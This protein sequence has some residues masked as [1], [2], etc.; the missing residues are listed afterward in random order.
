MTAWPLRGAFRNAGEI[1]HVPLV[2]D[3]EPCPCGNRGCLERYVSL[4][5]YER[6]S[7]GR[8]AA[9]A[10]SR[11]PHPLFRSAIV[12]IENLFDPE[13]IIV[14][15]IADDALLARPGRRRRAAAQFGLDRKDRSSAAH[16][17]L[18]RRA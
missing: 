4:E 5:A 9:T 1:G 6:R 10:G 15:G 16:H 3:G 14:G 7:A 11:K 12:T 8:S 17:A 13:T 18:G 2:P